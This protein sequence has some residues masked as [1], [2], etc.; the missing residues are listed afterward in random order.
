MSGGPL[1]R[2][3]TSFP[4]FL[5]SLLPYFL[6]PL[7]PYFLTS[8][9]PYFLTSLL[10]YFLNSLLPYL[11]ALPFA[12]MLQ[13][14]GRRETGLADK[15]LGLGRPEGRR[16]RGCRGVDPSARCVVTG[17]RGSWR[18]CQDPGVAQA[19]QD[20]RHRGFTSARRTQWRCKPCTGCLPPA[21]VLH[22]IY[23]DQFGLGCCLGMVCAYSCIAS[24]LR[25]VRMVS[26][27]V[28]CGLYALHV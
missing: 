23:L 5:T 1:R 10:P 21:D 12:A 27:A 4:H 8:L 2:Y 22:C 17:F 7:L 9:L 15:P 18:L 16:A 3:L 28:L 20:H 24:I 26:Y 13:L 25:V 19:P 11:L 6:T 14:R